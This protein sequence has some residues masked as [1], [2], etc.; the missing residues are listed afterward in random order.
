LGGGLALRIA[1]RDKPSGLSGTA[2]ILALRD[3]YDTVG[4]CTRR[5]SNRREVG[6]AKGALERSREASNARSSDRGE[7]GRSAVGRKNGP[8]AQAQKAMCWAPVQM[9]PATGLC[10]PRS[11]DTVVG[12][13]HQQGGSRQAMNLTAPPRWDLVGEGR[14][15]RLLTVDKPMRIIAV[16]LGHGYVAH[17]L[18]TR[19]DVVLAMRSRGPCRL[20]FFCAHRLRRQRRRQGAS[21]QASSGRTDGT[22]Q[23]LPVRRVQTIC[24][25]YGI[26]GARPDQFGL[27]SQIRARRPLTR[28]IRDPDVPG[29]GAGRGRRTVSDRT[30][31]SP[32]AGRDPA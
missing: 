20:F 11:G 16:R 3:P 17:R 23:S 1:H 21:R 5:R 12:R 25:T 18:G 13:H 10:K 6:R 27:E 32:Y 31:R 9:S 14:R 8:L 19:R 22:T 15:R 24:D 30:R 4:F 28:A 7:A 29:G 2:E 26:T